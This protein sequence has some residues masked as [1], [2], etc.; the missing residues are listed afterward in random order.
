MVSTQPE[1]KYKDRDSSV[2]KTNVSALGLH[3]RLDTDE[4]PGAKRSS[5]VSF[6]VLILSPIKSTTA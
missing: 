2:V 3:Q 5:T 4:A 1:D 6:L